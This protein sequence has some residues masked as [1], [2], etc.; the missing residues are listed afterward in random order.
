[1]CRFIF[2]RG[3]ALPLSSLLTEP[4]NS[5]IHQST[6]ARERKEP[7]N[8]DGFGVSW[9]VPGRESS[10]L[11][12]STSPAWSN[13]NLRSL[14]RVVESSCVLAHVRAASEGLEV[15]ET[16][17]HPFQRGRYTFMHNGAIGGFE[18]LRRPLQ[19][20]LSDDAF[21]AL[22][23]TT[24]S[25]HLFALFMDEMG[26]SGDEGGEACNRLA[27]ALERAVARAMEVASSHAPGQGH[28]L[29][30]LVS[31][32][33]RAVACRWAS[34]GLEPESLYV[35][36]G[37]R[38]LCEAGVCRMIDT[39]EGRGSRAALV[40]SEPLYDSGKWEPVPRNHLVMVHDTLEVEIREM[41]V[42]G[43]EA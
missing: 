4:E 8:G 3:E 29:N 20:S 42:A 6:H 27:E 38:Y 24:D 36:H 10:G 31:D 28:R 30:L 5:L 17:T 19:A 37:R 11:F 33:E 1:M 12:R 40:S 2:Y 25:E 18:T 9:Y 34:S 21:R 7:L 14:A 15:M 23:G 35:S 39:A 43:T 13:Q 41:R 26:R 22:R 32:G 16:N